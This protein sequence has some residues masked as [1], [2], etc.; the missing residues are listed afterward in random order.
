MARN[1]LDWSVALLT[2]VAVCCAAQAGVM[3]DRVA[4]AAGDRVAA[5]EFPALVIATVRDGKFEIA[6]F[7]ASA[8]GKLPTGDT[9]FEI[10]SVTKTFTGLLL[11]EAVQSGQVSL[12]DPLAKLLADFTLPTRGGKQITL[13]DLADQHS[14]LPRLPANMQPADPADPYAD[15]DSVSLRMF[16]GTYKLPRDPGAEYEYSNLGE[17]ILG[18]ALAAT[19]RTTYGDVLRQ[20]VLAP[21]GMND[22]GVALTDAMRA[23]LAP[24]HDADG[25]PV[26]NWN[27]DVLAGAGA[28]KSTAND[29][30]RYLRANMGLD[31][32]ALLPAM[33]LAQTPR[34]DMD[35]VDRVGL[36]WITRAT[37]QGRIVWHNGMTAGYASFL[38]FTAD[39]SRGVVVLANE[40]A[41]VDDLGFAALDDAA[42]LAPARKTIAMSRDALGAY[43]GVFR[44]SDKM[45]LQVLLL[46]DRLYI[47]ATGQ[48]PVPVYPSAPN[49]FFAKVADIA[50]TF[51]RDAKGGVDGLVLHQGGDH[52]AP[53]VPDAPVATLDAGTLASY[54][55]TYRFAPTAIF[56]IAL[57][58]GQLMAQLTGQPSLPVFPRAK[59]KL[60]YKVV[61]AQIDFE[62]G[63]DGTVVALVLHQNGRDLR[64]PKVAP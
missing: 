56:D 41:S 6:G 47:Q 23:H 18:Y 50:I 8:D 37:P 32:T 52:R 14:G 35:A 45:D 59:D 43:Q 34:A 27:F 38:G 58:D 60:F 25:K 11:A 10:G 16:L 53:R 2:A 55:G 3:P 19:A 17:G 63:P 40:A 4:Q 29:M 46:A 49:E 39:G 12:D 57:K 13:G 21:L 61:D 51:T 42:P 54:V 1:K 20:R 26:K 33:R 28:I 44:L 31:Q 48:G 64:A 7:R 30:L 15:Y 5:G 22:T 24:G 36:A 62:R 9:V